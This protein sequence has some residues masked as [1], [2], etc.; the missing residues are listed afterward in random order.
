M[1]QLR[2][3]PLTGRWVAINAERRQ[4]PNEFAVRSLPVETDPTRPCPFCPGRAEAEPAAIITATGPDGA[5]R[6]IVVP[7]L[8]PAFRG[9]GPMVVEHLGP[10][11]T[12]AE[13][14]G[15]HEV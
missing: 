12:R 1:S 15:A 3:D 11:F 13:A 10:V 8:Y 14:S 9:H 5:W 2:L 6:V 4:R 7:N